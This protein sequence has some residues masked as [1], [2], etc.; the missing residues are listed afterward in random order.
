[1]HTCI[2]LNWTAK[3]RKTNWFQRILI[4]GTIAFGII[5][6]TV[7]FS[8]LVGVYET[9]NKTMAGPCGKS[10]MIYRYR[11]PLE[12]LKPGRNL[13]IDDA[14]AIAGVSGITSITL[15][16]A[17]RIPVNLLGQQ[18]QIKILGTDP[19]FTLI[20]NLNIAKGRFL[21]MTDLLER[22]PVCVISERVRKCFFPAGD[23][24]EHIL[25]INGVAFRIV[26]C[27]RPMI[28]PVAFEK[29]K[30]Q[31]D[32]IIPFTTY[33]SLFHQYDCDQIWLSY[34]HEYDHRKKIILLKSRIKSILQYQHREGEVFILKTLDDA[35]NPQW[36]MTIIIMSSLL[37]IAFLSMITG[38]IGIISVMNVDQT[39]NVKKTIPENM[40][41]VSRLPFYS[42][43]F[44][45]SFLISVIGGSSGLFLGIVA[46][47]L[48][49]I[50][51]GIPTNPPWWV[52]LSGVGYIL[53]TAVIAGTFIN[54]NR[55]VAN[56]S[57][58]KSDKEDVF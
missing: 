20:H 15:Q 37:G 4:F 9:I 31:E 33:Q 44:G 53:L 3:T 24:L 25:E 23:C 36:K 29:S 8:L 45:E 17:R 13:D 39:K 57:L 1:M 18:V 2:L 12:I 46:S 10:M 52:L 50:F 35:T 21:V 7:A 14:R 27:L 26:G 30:A 55:R 47:K 34:A 42:Q 51:T 54:K 22:Q 6:L 5:A 49:A 11:E 38:S 16:S 28:L 56:R 58:R 40:V 19:D 32:I 48:I 43:I 41:K